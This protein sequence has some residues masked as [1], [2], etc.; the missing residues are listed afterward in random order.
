M[1]METLDKKYGP[2][3][4]KVEKIAYR[5]NR[6]TT[7]ALLE[8]ETVARMGMDRGKCVSLL[9]VDLS[10]AF[11]C[12]DA[13]IVCS[14]LTQL[15]VGQHAVKLKRSYLTNRYARTKIND[16]LSKMRLVETGVGQGS[17]IGPLLFLIAVICVH[18]VL[19]KAK[20][21]LKDKYN[22]KMSI[23]EK[24]FI[25]QT[26]NTQAHSDSKSVADDLTAVV[27][28]DTE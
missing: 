7:A 10:A 25:L 12:I 26:T 18:Q 6:S 4:G 16:C 8:I 11:D 21:I 2:A 28:T 3:I 13:E 5:E 1:K 9:L 27:I 14:K 22:I 15:S 20:Q 23:D 17:V 24:D 19:K